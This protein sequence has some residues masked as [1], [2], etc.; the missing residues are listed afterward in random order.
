MQHPA[1]RLQAMI[2]TLDTLLEQTALSPQQV[3]FIQ[4]M[5]RT[6]DE[7]LKAVVPIPASE[8]ALQRIIPTFGDSFLQQHAVLF[9]YARMLLKHPQSFDGVQLNPVQTTQMQTVYQVG[10]A[11]YAQV[12]QWINGAQAHQQAG[13]RACAE[14]IDLHALFN[15]ERPIWRYLVRHCAVEIN[16][17]CT[18]ALSV[19]ASDYHLRALLTHCVNVISAELMTTGTLYI[20]ATPMRLF[21]LI[22][23]RADG[24]D[25]TP[26]QQAML[27]RDKGRYIYKRRVHQYEGGLDFGSTEHNASLFIRFPFTC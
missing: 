8:H 26:V 19:C 4:H 20:S 12:A 11:L 27:F 5:R 15:A 6:A 21:A 1:E 3:T 25:F 22:D 17:T 23:I 24:V 13:L 7:L 10:Q 9:G 16:A 2:I 14:P 18:P